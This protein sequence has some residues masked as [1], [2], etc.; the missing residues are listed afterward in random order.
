VSTGDKAAAVALILALVVA[1]LSFG[2][3]EPATLAGVQ[4]LLLVTT[5]ALLVAGSPVLAQICARSLLVPAALVA[6]ALLQLVPLPVA[7]AG[8]VP[9]PAAAGA[10]TQTVD[11]QETTAGL[12]HLLACVCAFVL[13][14]GV[15]RA[16]G[17]ARL[18]ALSLVTLG[19]FE[20]LY[21]LVQYLTGWQQI[22]FYV[23]QF[24]LDSASGTYI[25]RN[26]YAGLL[27]MI[28]PFCLALAFYYFGKSPQ[29]ARSRGLRE[30]LAR[31]EV[32]RS[33]FW[34]F[35]AAVLL[36]ALA[37]SRSRMGILSSCAATLLML[38][39]IAAGRHGR[40]RAALP[41]A[42]LAIGIGLMVWIGPG[43]LVERFERIEL[44]A[45]A[46][47]SR[48]TIWRD[49][50]ALVGRHPWLGSGLG[51][52]PIA[53]TSVQTAFFGR[54]V[55]SAHNDYL[56]FAADLGI[57]AA[58]LLF[59]SI[60]F[61]G[62]RAA[63]RFL[64]GEAEFARALAL[65]C[66]GSIAAILLHSFADFNL[67]IPANALVFAAVLGLAVGAGRWRIRG[68]C[69]MSRRISLAVKRA[70]DVTATLAALLV[71]SPLLA[72]LALLVKRDTGAV[73]FR[74]ERI[75]Q[76]G[77]VFRILKF[78]TMTDARDPQGELLPDDERLTP[79][80]RFLRRSSLD[81][82][83]ELW[84]VLR[85]EM[86]LVGPRPLLA[87]YL[88]RYTPE[89]ARRHDVRP[90]VTGLAQASGRNAL[91]WEEKFALDV[92]YVDQWSLGLDLRILART[93]WLVLRGAGVSQPGCATAEE[94][95]PVPARP[96]AGEGA[97][98]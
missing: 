45:S 36:L 35:L 97:E 48:L 38:G 20:A 10:A 72:L 2:G 94:F 58:L 63:R 54:L 98:R 43:P 31:V 40:G 62:V 52:F 82:L 80:G 56:E 60:V 14:M 5:A 19:A 59:G 12:V 50:L 46:K 66:A 93:A 88:L 68:G 53:Y 81:E 1:V 84:N 79:L 85:G 74:Q 4:A 65:G 44:E 24:S 23:K 41:V 57:P 76:H 18:L 86:S 90:G 64:H 32:S 26:H 25:N 83:P 96:A 89:Q 11:A 28:F 33:I 91:T 7:S 95:Q 22:F 70:L 69:R 21:G 51:T 71:L 47:D 34:L 8:A 42:L 3:T 9:F 29:A 6:V 92:R 37:A 15:A 61:A 39:L 55:N 78:R 87:R 16:R 77:R 13:A 73:L 27:E 75:G 67:Q 17:G 49:T 30:W